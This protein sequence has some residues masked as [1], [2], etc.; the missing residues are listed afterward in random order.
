MDLDAYFARIGFNGARVP[1]L[2]T[3][4][5]LHLAH[6][7]AIA[8]ENLNPLL[9]WRVP[10]DPLS[11][12]EKLVHSGR[13][14]YCFE[15]NAL[16]AT[17]LRELGFKV[18]GLA[19]RVLWNA[20]EEAIRA[21]SHMLLKI[22]LDGESHIADVGF[23]GLTLTGPLRLIA[24][25]EQPTPHERFRLAGI[26]D[27]F[28]LQARIGDAWKSLYRFDLQ[29]QNDVDYEVYNH[30]MSTHP[31]SH[32]RSMLIAAR[33]VPGGRYALS[34]NQL[35]IHRIGAPSERRVL[36]SVD[37]L[38]EVLESMFGLTLPPTA[39]LDPALARVCGFQG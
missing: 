22:D 8:F 29:P 33:P 7:Q 36:A 14:G 24:D 3:L 21:R 19:A 34:N 31:T 11:L 30:Y 39:E 32:F 1:T 37:E 23:G 9:G 12:E 17:A 4:R 2:G 18:T 38:R 28:R 16:L 10:L 26:D 27:G 13:G 25:R 15:Q 20:P 5:E 6:A 35:A